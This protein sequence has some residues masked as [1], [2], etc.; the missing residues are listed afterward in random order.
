[1][2]TPESPFERYLSELILSFAYLMCPSVSRPKVPKNTCLRF[3]VLNLKEKL[4]NIFKIGWKNME[5]SYKNHSRWKNISKEKIRRPI[6][7]VYVLVYPLSK[8]GGNQTNSQWALAFYSG[9]FKWKNWFKKTALN[10]SIRQ[11]IFTSRQN[12]K[13]PFLCQY[14]IFF[15][16]FFFTLEILFES[17][18]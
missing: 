18:L 16:Y 3:A 17:S 2:Q 6:F 15:N 4:Q 14:L 9:R 7:V 13:L 5:C 1:M 10:M 12:L 8:L 11:V